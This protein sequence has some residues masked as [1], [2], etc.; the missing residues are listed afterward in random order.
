[1]LR[2][3]IAPLGSQINGEHL[4][5]II[6]QMVE[7]LG[8]TVARQSSLRQY[9][10]SKHWHIRRPHRSGT[11]EITFWP[12]DLRLWVTVHRGR[13][14]SWAEEGSRWVAQELARALGSRAELVPE[15]V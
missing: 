9:P 6:E 12:E 14:G 13:E 11:V 8:L 1:M 7:D 3:E 5:Q 4:A 10:G 15:M 2:W